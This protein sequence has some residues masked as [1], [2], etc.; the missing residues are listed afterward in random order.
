MDVIHFL[1]YLDDRLENAKRLD[2]AGDCVPGRIEQLGFAIQQV[3]NFLG[4]DPS[5][6]DGGSDSQDQADGCGNCEAEAQAEQTPSGVTIKLTIPVGC[7]FVRFGTLRQH[8]HYVNAKGD[9]K[10]WGCSA[11]SENL[12]IVVRRS[13]WQEPTL[14]DLV[15]EFPIPCRV[16]NSPN[17][18]WFNGELIA[19]VPDKSYDQRFI[20]GNSTFCKW[21][22]Y[23]EIRIRV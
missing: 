22:R 4:Y 1:R 13:E 18:S 10:E 6:K 8:D 15:D 2:K 9:V 20:V 19:M 16:R 17:E 23:C 14:Q 7:E 3:K 11:E 21:W 12:Y 5:E